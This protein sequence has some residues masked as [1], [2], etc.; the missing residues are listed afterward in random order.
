M[1]NVLKRKEMLFNNYTR[2]TYFVPKIMQFCVYAVK[3]ILKNYS[4]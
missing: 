3:L 2:Q 1:G 4:V